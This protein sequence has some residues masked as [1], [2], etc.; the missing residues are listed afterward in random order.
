[1]RTSI[2][3]L[4]AL[5]LF[6]A[7]NVVRADDT[8][9][10]P[11]KPEPKRTVNIDAAYQNQNKAAPQ[12]LITFQKKAVTKTAD[13]KFEGADV[14]A[15]ASFPV[16]IKTELPAANQSIMLPTA[17]AGFEYFNGKVW[18]KAEGETALNLVVRG[19]VD[20]NTGM[21]NHWTALGAAGIQ[22]SGGSEVAPVGTLQ[23]LPLQNGFSYM[24]AG[25]V[26]AGAGQIDIRGTKS[27]AMVG[28]RLEEAVQ[29]CKDVNN[30][31]MDFICANLSVFQRMG[32]EIG[33]GANA[34]I[35]YAH[36]I[37]D[38]AQKG[39]FFVAPTAGTEVIAPA[40]DP[41]NKL[42]SYTFGA[43]VGVQF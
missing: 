34:S 14:T 9:G 20:R 4:I 25:M 5:G 42:N 24:L 6:S 23:T 17:K 36:Q 7:G 8:D 43:K 31:K 40:S 38:S 2:L 28:L 41:C 13:G 26:Q 12:I 37:D 15:A 16:A 3:I 21:G 19:V 35:M 18:K 33:G 1:M 27:V 10:D 29:Y 30:N 11:A 39:Y 32:T 22:F